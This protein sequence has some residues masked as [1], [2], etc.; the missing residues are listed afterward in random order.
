MNQNKRNMSKRRRTSQGAHA[1][2]NG[3]VNGTRK[4]FTH[5][6][7]MQEHAMLRVSAI[8]LGWLFG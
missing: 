4:M 2:S 8:S 5:N 3:Q 6:A 7:M 1:I